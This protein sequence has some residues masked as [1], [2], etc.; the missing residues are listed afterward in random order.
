[1]KAYPKTSVQVRAVIDSVKA[2]ASSDAREAIDT[3]EEQLNARFLGWHTKLTEMLAWKG[4]S[5]PPLDNI[6]SRPA[7][8]CLLALWAIIR[9][10]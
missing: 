3:L 8:M 10:S 1:M 4:P 9:M 5:L 2:I 6:P 7:A